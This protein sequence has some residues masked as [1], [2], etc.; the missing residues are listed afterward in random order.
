VSFTWRNK[1]DFGAHLPLIDFDGDGYSL[2]SL[3]SYAEAARDLGYAALAA[4]DHML[5]A[6]PWLDG[7][8]ALAAT[9]AHSGSMQLMTTVA[10]PVIRGP[11]QTAKT[12]GAIDILS[13]GRLI[14]GV[15]PGSSR[16]DYEAVALDFEER[17]KRLDDAV[18]TL[19]ALWRKEQV[20]GRFYSTNGIALEPETAQ[21]Q[22]PPVWIGSWGS[23]AGLRRTARLGDG[24][25]A[26]A[27][28]T[29]PEAFATAWRRLLEIRAEIGGPADAYPNA[30]ATMWTYVTDDKAEGRHMIEDVLAPML[31]RSPEDL[32]DRLTIGPA[33]VCAEKLTALRAAGAQR[34]LIWPISEPARQLETFKAKVEPLIPNT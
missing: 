21:A 30:L 8:T 23:E 34:V 15:G 18:K 4:N 19:R 10:L 24:W 6:R 28:N 3:T 14:V 11:V 32:L 12:L 13:G 5:F 2:A 29:T 20:R 9:V 22:G 26:S 16:A 17:W 1:V 25:L 33:E 7:P 31:R 27:Y